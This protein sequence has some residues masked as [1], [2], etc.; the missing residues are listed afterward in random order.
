MRCG[1]KNQLCPANLLA[2]KLA[3]LG[4]QPASQ[5]SP[6]SEG[7]EEASPEPSLDSD[8]VEFFCGSEE[9]VHLSNWSEQ[10]SASRMA[11]AVPSK[12][13]SWMAEQAALQGSGSGQR[14]ADRSHIWQGIQAAALALPTRRSTWA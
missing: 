2:Q 6:I 9:S 3:Q 1:A 14:Y 13:H 12:P 7:L 8:A 11:D 5:P 10:Q 4:V